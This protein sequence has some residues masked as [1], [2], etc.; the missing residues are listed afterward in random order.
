MWS[1]FRI[2][3][4]AYWVLLPSLYAGSFLTKPFLV[5]GEVDVAEIFSSVLAFSASAADLSE[6]CSGTK[7]GPR[8]ILTAAHCFTEELSEGKALLIKR[9]ILVKKIFYS[10][11][12]VVNSSAKSQEVS[13]ERILFHPELETCFSSSDRSPAECVDKYP[14]LAIVEVK[15]NDSFTKENWASVDLNS[16]QDGDPVVI[17]GYGAQTDNDQSPPVRKFHR[18]HVVSIEDL[19]KSHGGV[20]PAELSIYKELYFGAWGLLMGPAY[21]NLGAG[22]SGGPVFTLQNGQPE[23]VGVN[24]FSYCQDQELDCEIT[25]NSY[26]TRL[27]SG[28]SH[29]LGEWVLNVIDSNH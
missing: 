21:A 17:V 3:F 25:S 12:S 20:T 8:L 11:S 23:L 27:H 4:F 1:T 24:S 28:S 22:D 6:R 13:V 16:V 10:F 29:R 19:V 26:F 18:S 14:D 9:N 7:I 5:G 2:G 15:S